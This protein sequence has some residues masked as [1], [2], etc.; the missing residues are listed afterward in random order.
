MNVRA[1][2]DINAHVRVSAFESPSLN[3]KMI[4]SRR[5]RLLHQRAG[6]KQGDGD[7]LQRD[8]LARGECHRVDLAVS[9]R[10]LL[11]NVLGAGPSAPCMPIA[12]G[13]NL[14][15]HFQDGKPFGRVARYGAFG[16]LALPRSSCALD[17]TSSR[18]APV[19]GRMGI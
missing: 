4:R 12:D 11:D 10:Q 7:G 17:S 3:A 1:R 19:N 15:R 6:A 13:R 14:N 5:A 16:G 2:R 8:T 9:L 18:C